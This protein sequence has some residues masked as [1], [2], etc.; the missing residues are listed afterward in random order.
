MIKFWLWLGGCSASINVKHK[1]LN[2][3]GS[4]KEVFF[5]EEKDFGDLDWL[6]A[7]DKEAF[8]SKKLTKAYEILDLCGEKKV[9][10]ITFQD[11][12][13]PERLRNIYDPPL[14]LYVKGRLP[15]IDEQAAIA[16]VGTRG[17][18]PYGIKSAQRLGYEMARAGALI[19]SGLAAGIDSS[20]A[21]GAIKAGK[22]VVGVL[23]CSIDEVYPKSNE[24]LYDDV[25][26]IGALVSEYPPGYPIKRENFPA[27]NRI[28]SGLSVGVVVI[29]APERSGALITAGIALEQGRELFVV[30]GNVDSA[31]SMGSNRLLSESAAKAV[32]TAGDVLIEFE[33][34]FPWKLKPRKA[35]DSRYL[36]I[37]KDANHSVSENENPTNGQGNLKK[38]IDKK[39]DKGYIDLQ[40]QL[41]GLSEDE[42]SL[43]SNMSKVPKH[44]DDI[45]DACGLPANRVLAAM[46]MLQIKGHV[47]EHK[48]KKFSLIIIK[49]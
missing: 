22:Q 19:V 32:I 20:A 49:K 13:Y 6:S 30:P 4:P 9:D 48:G 45:I 8:L 34:L 24:H 5:A 29:E 37:D 33:G 40:E 36:G 46:T 11:A 39:K 16:V 15:A 31:N 21:I 10:I 23:G 25:E 3:F 1:V 7:K 17:A 18:T 38:V 44:I 14:V 28:V 12:R 27:R 2:Y 43:V 41:E 35:P 47:A 26:Q 42:L